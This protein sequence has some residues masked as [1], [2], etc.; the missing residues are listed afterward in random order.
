[1][2]RVI[3]SEHSSIKNLFNSN[4]SEYYD[5]QECETSH[6]DETDDRPNKSPDLRRTATTYYSDK[7]AS[8][9]H[10]IILRFLLCIIQQIMD[11]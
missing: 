4:L 6:E 7:V 3:H 11:T 5:A 9:R 2:E 8:Q 1:M 10:P